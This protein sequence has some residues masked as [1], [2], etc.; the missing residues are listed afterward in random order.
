MDQLGGQ[1][2]D[3]LQGNSAQKQVLADQEIEIYQGKLT[4]FLTL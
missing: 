3:V 4:F 1:G 2:R